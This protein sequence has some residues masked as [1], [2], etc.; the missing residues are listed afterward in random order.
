M[1]HT[2]VTETNTLSDKAK[3]YKN[4]NGKL[5]ANL[6]LNV[7]YLNRAELATETDKANKLDYWASLFQSDTWEDL[8]RLAVQDPLGEE[9]AEVMYEAMIQSEEQ[10][11]FEA[12]Q[13]YLDY[14]SAA[15]RSGLAEGYDKGY[16]QHLITQICKKLARG[17]SADQ[18]ALEV[19]E[20]PARVATI[21][22]IAKKYAPKYDVESIASELHETPKAD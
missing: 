3:A 19:E 17:L 12:H 8:K 22:N 21:C 11:M 5:K 6:R 9:V 4:A 10:T 20:D 14:L 7:L 2:E 16:E 18:I 13:R 1:K 15:K